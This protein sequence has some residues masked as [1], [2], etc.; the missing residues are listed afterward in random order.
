MNRSNKAVELFESGYNCSQ[1]IVLA[2]EDLFNID[3]TSFKFYLWKII[4]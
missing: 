2:F 1:A 3:K 4:K